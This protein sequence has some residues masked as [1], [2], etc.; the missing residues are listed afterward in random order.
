M[1]KTNHDAESYFSQ[2]S[3]GS[4]AHPWLTRTG[5]RKRERDRGERER[6]EREIDGEGDVKNCIKICRLRMHSF[7]GAKQD[8]IINGIKIT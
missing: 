5:T 4:I 1:F 8:K 3:K 7:E 6:G 2:W